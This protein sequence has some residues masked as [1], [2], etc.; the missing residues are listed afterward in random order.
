MAFCYVLYLAK[1]FPIKYCIFNTLKCDEQSNAKFFFEF[2]KQLIDL[3]NKT[4]YSY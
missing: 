3:W 2:L 4:Y 1:T